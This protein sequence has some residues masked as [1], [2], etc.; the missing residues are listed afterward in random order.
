MV[1][2]AVCVYPIHG[3]QDPWPELDDQPE[4]PDLVPK[5]VLW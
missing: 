1:S 5:G 2:L 3:F 4:E